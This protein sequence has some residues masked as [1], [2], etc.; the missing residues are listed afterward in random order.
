MPDLEDF[1]RAIPKVELHFHL[2]GTIRPSTFKALARSAKASISDA[3]IDVLYERGPGKFAGVLKAFRTLD[4]DV[5]RTPDDLARITR[6]YLEDAAAHNVRYSECFWNPT[7]TVARSG[8][9]FDRAQG[10][11]VRAIHDAEAD[12]GIVG[13]LIVAIDREAPPT[14]AMEVVDWMR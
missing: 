6:E 11:I 4:A 8:I 3:E 7:G 9:A 12:L 14:A 13:R 1:C 10:A 2:L 5:I